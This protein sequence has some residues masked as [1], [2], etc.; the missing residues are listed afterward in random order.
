MKATIG[1]DVG[2]TTI[3]GGLVTHEGDILHD[4]QTPTRRDGPGT[5]V[6]RLLNVIDELLK[7][8]RSRDVSLEGIGVGVAGAVDP[9][10]GTML[11]FAGNLL[12][13]LAHLPLAGDIRR[14]TSLPVFVDND[15]NAL[16]LAEWRFGVGRGAHSLVLLAL[17][18]AVGGG[19]IMGD[20]LIRGHRGYAGEFHA[21]PINFDGPP[22]RFGR[23]CLGEYIGGEAIAAEARQQV[24]SGSDVALLELAGRDRSKITSE[25]VFQAACCGDPLA[26]AIVD[27]MCEALAAGIGVIVNSFNPEVV[28]VTGGVARSLVPLEEDLRRRV[29]AYALAPAL[30]STRICVVGGDKRQTVRGGAALVL[31]ELERARPSGRA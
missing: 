6:V 1:V 17:G 31:Y 29:S 28:V 8:A 21:V 26:K 12:P 24:G 30:A 5:V 20:A 10:K 19:V 3:S 7:V 27:R 13:E 23:G 15:A 11:P 2:A 18:T 9:E 4:V 14:V 16:A 25:L 22:G